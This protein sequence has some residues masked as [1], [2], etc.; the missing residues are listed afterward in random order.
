MS[1]LNDKIFLA[2]SNKTWEVISSR[3][4]KVTFIHMWDFSC[5]QRASVAGGQPER[6]KEYLAPVKF[7]FLLKSGLFQLLKNNQ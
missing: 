7:L 3:Q 4:V 6:E 2:E 1:T 5:L